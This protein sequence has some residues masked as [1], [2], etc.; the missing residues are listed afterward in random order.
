[1]FVKTT[2]VRRGNRSYEYLS[3]VEA[4]RT[5][6][7]V[8][9]RTLLRLG[10]VSE[11]RS[12]GQLERV[13]TALRAHLEPGIREAVDLAVLHAESA[14]AFGGVAACD[15]LWREVGLD[16]WFAKQGR[17]R[18]ASR[19]GDAAFSIVA[20]RLVDPCSKRRLPEWTEHDVAMPAGWVEPSADQY[21]RALDAIADT[22]AATEMFLYSALTT[23]V[24]LDL[25][26]VCY[27]IT[28]TY[29]EGDPRPSD[30]F[31][32]KPFGYSRDTRS[33]RPQIVIGLLVTGD[34]I[35]I[36]HH[37]FAGNTS[38]VST[39]PDV[40]DDLRERFGVGR[41]C[42]VADR[43]FISA[44]NIEKLD[45]DGFDHVLATRLHRDTLCEQ[46]LTASCAPDAAWVPVPDANSAAAEVEID[47]TRCVVVASLER[48]HRDT[49]RTQ[50]LVQRTETELLALESR[51]R[52]GRLQDAGKIG[53]AAQRILS[54]SG[55][56]R[57]FDLEINEGRF[58]YHYNEH[59]FAYEQ[60][61]AGRYVLHT[62]LTTQQASTGQVVRH[63]RGLLDVEA[64]FRVLKDFLRL[65]PIRHWTENR[66]RGHVAACIYASVIEALI[67]QRLAAAHIE[68][69]D[70]AGQ[71]LSA[72]RALRELDRIRHVTLDADGRHVTLVTRRNPLQT[73]ILNALGVDTNDWDRATINSPKPG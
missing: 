43:G 64:R 22:K 55:I 6:G 67:N 47:G 42:V 52:D 41:I 32:S 21:Y 63:Y 50:E 10:E 49:A 15:A 4:E 45:A 58:V 72:S 13:I 7:K 30:R 12:S 36:A 24:N 9:H 16:A 17:S 61:L 68:D 38:D 19:L 37:V 39:L 35:P 20:N 33:D 73:R 31:P 44:A 26:L 53:R 62:S 5:G 2:R 57:L 28:S 65:R 1:M 18:R 56:G 25:R 27:D 3:L 59:A 14:R 69:P 34:G 46:A 23:L 48:H 66:V 70:I 29:F 11:L 8:G 51:V 54:G 60:L 71:Q 40:L